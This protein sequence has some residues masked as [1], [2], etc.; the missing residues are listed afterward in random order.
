M[1]VINKDVVANRKHS[2]EEEN[3]AKVNR[4]ETWMELFRNFFPLAVFYGP[5]FSGTQEDETANR[6][7]DQSWE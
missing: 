2:F 5:E 1:T 7:C 4:S 6:S 3:A